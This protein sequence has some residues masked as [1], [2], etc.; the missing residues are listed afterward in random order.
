MPIFSLH[1][2]FSIERGIYKIIKSHWDWNWWLKKKS[3]I[4][5][6]QKS[7]LSCVNNMHRK[8]RTKSLMFARFHNKLFANKLSIELEAMRFCVHCMYWLIGNQW[9]VN[10]LVRGFDALHSNRNSHFPC[11]MAW[12]RKYLSSICNGFF[13]SLHKIMAN[14]ISGP[15]EC[16][17]H[18]R[19]KR[20]LYVFYIL[21]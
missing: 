18:S 20:H 21:K 16:V 8:K 3:Y 19:K 10:M 13:F 17:C 2:L 7:N 12:K 5:N 6:T 15:K 1:K 11:K 14:L 4:V 9:T